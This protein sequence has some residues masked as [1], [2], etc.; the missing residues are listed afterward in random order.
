[1]TASRTLIALVA[2]AMAAVP[3][4][5]LADKGGKGK[6]HGHG[7]PGHSVGNGKLDKPGNAGKGGRDDRDPI[8]VVIG[9]SERRV[10]QDYFRVSP[11]PAKGLPPGIAKNLARGK[12][13]PPGIAKRHLPPDLLVRLPPRPGYEWVAVG[14]DV[15]LLAI[16]TGIVVDILSDAF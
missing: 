14:R 15:V 11:Y 4:G 12:P 7:P 3:A 6:D 8:G 9:S 5:T 16:A 1:M 2:V 13:L 10:I